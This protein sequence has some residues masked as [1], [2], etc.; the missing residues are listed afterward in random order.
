MASMFVERGAPAPQESTNR[1]SIRMFPKAPTASQECLIYVKLPGDGC[2]RKGRGRALG[3]LEAASE[4]LRRACVVLEIAMFHTFRPSFFFAVALVA[5]ALGSLAPAN[6]FDISGVWSTQADLCDR[7][8]VKKGN[9]VEFTELSDLFGSGFIIDGNKIKGKAA[10]C[11]IE[12]RKQDGEILKLSSACA[13]TIMTQN[14]EFQLKIVDDNNVLRLFPEISGM[15]VNYA[16]C[17]M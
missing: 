9:Q 15:S 1:Q 7:V 16:R 4:G 3:L 11:T 12:S 2:A 13:T 10:S 5:A 8:F 14:V 17:K 6:A